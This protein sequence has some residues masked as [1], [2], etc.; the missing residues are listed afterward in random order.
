[1]AAASWSVGGED[2]S[3]IAADGGG[4]GWRTTKCELG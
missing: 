3:V 2:V 1:V 4:E